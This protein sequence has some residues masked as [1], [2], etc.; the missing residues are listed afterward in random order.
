M[1][2]VESLI[3]GDEVKLSGRTAVF[4]GLGLYPGSAT[5]R[6]VVW[7]LDTGEFSVDALRHDQEVGEIISTGNNRERLL[8][9]LVRGG[10]AV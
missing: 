8:L 6:T 1:A 10:A 9:S 3:P 7:K 5:L 2:T 4:I